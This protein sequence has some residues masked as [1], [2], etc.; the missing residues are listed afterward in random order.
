MSKI[1][2]GDRVIVRSS[3]LK[4]FAIKQ[5]HAVLIMKELETVIPGKPGLFEAPPFNFLQAQFLIKPPKKPLGPMQWIYITLG[6]ALVLH[7]LALMIMGSVLNHRLN[8][9]KEKSLALY[10]EVFPGATK[11]TS[12]KSL[13][14]RELNTRGTGAYDPLLD[15]IASLSTALTQIPG[16]VL[17]NLDYHQN[18]LSVNLTLPSMDA[19]DLLD[20]ALKQSQTPAQDQQITE[21]G[22]AVLVQFTLSSG[23]SK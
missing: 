14:E 5:E 3:T 4:G 15:L 10:S 8:D 13:I 1:I 18:R 17:N 12:A 22:N 23:E 16:A 6:L 9:L 2:S 21:Q 20:Q 19:V 11:V 7:L